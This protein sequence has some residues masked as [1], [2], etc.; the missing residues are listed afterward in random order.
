MKNVLSLDVI[1]PTIDEIINLEILIPKLLNLNRVSINQIIVIDDSKIQ[2]QI[3]LMEVS[4]NWPSNVKIIYRSGKSGNLASAI[5]DGVLE[6]RA[7]LVAWLDADNSMPPD[8]IGDL[9]E[10][11]SDLNKIII[12][13]RFVEG[14]GYKGMTESNKSLSIS[15]IFRIIKSKESISAILLSRM[16]NKTIRFITFGNI[17]DFT[18]GYILCKRD[19]AIALLPKIG[20]GEYCIE[21]L[22][23]AQRKGYRVKEIGYLC[24][25][26]QHG[27]S[28]TGVSLYSLVKRGIPYLTTALKNRRYLNFVE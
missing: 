9:Y 19:I 18:S 17:N 8:L 11:Y 1:L 15:W 25:P 24:H 6:S 10:N 27:Y 14:G 21:F 2:T 5:R 23:T 13:S 12:G 26:R 3:R 4:K 20:Y 7:E 22:S 28:K 16:L